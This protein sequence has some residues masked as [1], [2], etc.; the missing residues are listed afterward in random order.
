MI[1]RNDIKKRKDE[2]YRNLVTKMQSTN[3]YR[4]LSEQEKIPFRSMQAE[5]LSLEDLAR[6]LSHKSLEDAILSMEESLSKCIEKEYYC[7]A[8]GLRRVKE[9]I[10]SK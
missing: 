2:I 7:G 1:T 9:W 10:K 4:E 8:E 6:T 3:G 5:I